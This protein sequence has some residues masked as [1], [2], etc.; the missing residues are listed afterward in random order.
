MDSTRSDFTL[1]LP[2]C[3]ETPGQT[4]LLATALSLDAAKN[5]C[6]Q[7]FLKKCRNVQLRLP[8]DKRASWPSGILDSITLQWAET[9]TGAYEGHPVGCQNTPLVDKA[10]VKYRLNRAVKD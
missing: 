6:H 10:G 3:Q 5:L 9:E 2:S 4:Q 8:Q 7:H 1:Y